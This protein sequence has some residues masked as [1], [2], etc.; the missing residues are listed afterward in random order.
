M[1]DIAAH[2]LEGRTLQQ[3]WKVVKKIAKDT[4]DAKEKDSFFSVSYEVEKD[5]KKYFLKAFDITG[6]SEVGKTFME[7][8]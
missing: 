4:K 7:N 2:N 1:K 5:E 8:M 6:F 3:G